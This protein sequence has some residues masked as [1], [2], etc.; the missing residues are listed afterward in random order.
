MSAAER[1]RRCPRT[2]WSSA[3]AASPPPTTCRCDLRARRAPCADRPER[4]RQDHAD[5]PADRRAR[6]DRGPHRARRRGHHR[7]W[8]RTSACA[9]GMVRTFQIN[10]LFDQHDA[11]GDAGARGL[12]AARARARSWWQPLGARRGAWPSA[13]PQLLE[14]FRLAD[15]MDQRTEHARLRQAPPARDRHRAGLRAARAAARRAGGRRAGGRARGAAA[16]PWPRCRPT[17]RCC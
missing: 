12:A 11:A 16:R 15:V 9:R 8:R 5:Q 6:A 4:R 10:Q 2:A 1:R 13:A 17:C 7:A 14:Q 3:S